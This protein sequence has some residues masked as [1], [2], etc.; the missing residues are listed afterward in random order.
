VRVINHGRTVH[1]FY[2]AWGRENLAAAWAP[3]E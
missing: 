1:E 2:L 3:K